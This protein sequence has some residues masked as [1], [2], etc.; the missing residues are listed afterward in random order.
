MD[1]LTVK[2]ATKWAVDYCRSGKGPLVMEV[3][4]YRYFGH[5]MS[6]P[7]SRYLYFSVSGVLYEHRTYS[8]SCSLSRMWTDVAAH[9]ENL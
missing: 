2:E 6:D 8:Y 9:D 7:G 4:T 3:E 5:S 1:V